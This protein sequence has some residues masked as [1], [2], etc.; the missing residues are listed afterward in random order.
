[1]RTMS[2]RARTLI[3][4]IFCSTNTSDRTDVP[5]IGSRH[6]Q[7][8]HAFPS[9]SRISRFVRLKSIQIDESIFV[10]VRA[11]RFHRQNGAA[12]TE[13][14]RS[15]ETRR[16]I[17]SGRSQ[18]RRRSLVN[19]A[20]IFVAHRFVSLGRGAGS[21]ST[22]MVNS[23]VS[24]P[25][26]PTDSLWTNKFVVF[27]SPLTPIARQGKLSLGLFGLRSHQRQR[28]NQQ[29]LHSRCDVRNRH[30][31]ETFQS[32]SESLLA[33]G[34]GPDRANSHQLI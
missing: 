28:S 7:E 12:E 18:H 10:F 17:P 3:F 6:R 1:M 11:K 2:R 19:F 9:E 32:A 34:N 8:N 23:A 26:A 22:G 13:G 24:S 16:S 30:R 14:G 27:L 33:V 5:V 25:R 31:H 15:E 20:L 21:R 29:R 4:Q